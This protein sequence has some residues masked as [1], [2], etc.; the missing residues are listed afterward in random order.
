[1]T[2][3]HATSLS[4]T[5]MSM[6]GNNVY[7]TV[8][9]DRKNAAMPGANLSPHIDGKIAARPTVPA[10]RAGVTGAMFCQGAA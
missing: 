4:R 10:N 2:I 9:T 7:P 5:E 1:M 8:V 6:L 3:V